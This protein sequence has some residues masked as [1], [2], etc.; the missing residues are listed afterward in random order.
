MNTTQ[1]N[2]SN[3]LWN[4]EASE[5]KLI[6]TP[7]ELSAEQQFSFTAHPLEPLN[8]QTLHEWFSFRIQN[9]QSE[10]GICDREWCIKTEKNGSPSASNSFLNMFGEKLTVGYNG[11]PVDDDSVFVLQ[12]LSTKEV[13]LMLR[14]GTAYDEIVI[15]AKNTLPV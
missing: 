10:L 2:F 9:L 3:R 7:E 13:M 6:Y 1:L 5:G 4:R 14:Y 11:V 15:D 8:R 12:M